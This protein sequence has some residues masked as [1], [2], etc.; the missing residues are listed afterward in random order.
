MQLNKFEKTMK[1][2]I[3]EKTYNVRKKNSVPPPSNTHEKKKNDDGVNETEEFDS[4][5]K[6]YAHNDKECKYWK[7]VGGDAVPC[8]HCKTCREQEGKNC[9]FDECEAPATTRR[10]GM[11]FCGQH[12]KEH[13]ENMSLAM[14]ESF[15]NEIE[16]FLDESA[17]KDAVLGRAEKASKKA[18]AS[19]TAESHDA[20]GKA[21]REA[22][23]AAEVAGDHENQHKHQEAA[24]QH[25]DESKRLRG[26]STASGAPRKPIDKSVGVS[27][28]GKSNIKESDEEFFGLGTG[29]Q[30]GYIYNRQE[31][32]KRKTRVPMHVI[33]KRKAAEDKLNLQ[34]AKVWDRAGNVEKYRCLVDMFGFD[35]EDARNFAKLSFDDVYDTIR[36]PG[37]IRPLENIVDYFTVATSDDEHY[38]MTNIQS[39]NKK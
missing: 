29:P 35:R 38:K 17:P 25:S 37:S 36:V 22:S 24:A 9:D 10:G 14:G 15:I 7:V 5:F 12:A 20:A 1:K 19:G 28:F 8:G 32:K 2:T 3:T 13:D 33:N 31:P 23:N 11:K 27:G 30:N 4:A 26:V 16:S 18:H 39:E 6:N 21:H 34:A